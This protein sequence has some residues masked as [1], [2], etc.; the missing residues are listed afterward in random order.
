MN[1]GPGL[2]PEMYQTNFLRGV[3][4]MLLSYEASAQATTLFQ[5]MAFKEYVALLQMG[6]RNFCQ[7]IKCRPCDFLPAL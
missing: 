2:E 7:E 6:L 3:N 4:K 1:Q 5:H